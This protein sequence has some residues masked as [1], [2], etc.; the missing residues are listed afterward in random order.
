MERMVICA[1]VALSGASIGYADDEQA[2]CLRSA[3]DVHL[4][5]KTKL[6]DAAGPLMSPD[7]QI[8]RRRLDE[9]YCLQVTACG[10][11][12]VSGGERSMVGSALFSQCLAAEQ[13]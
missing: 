7:A 9:K 1:L 3:F 13:R 12:R 11:E 8:A 5:A 10:V 6:F 2:A 4:E